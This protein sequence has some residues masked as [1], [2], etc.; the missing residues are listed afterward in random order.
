[1]KE[2]K[3]LDMYLSDALMERPYAFSAGAFRFYLY[4][5]TFGKMQ[6]LQR[7][8]ENLDIDMDQLQKDVSI[9][10]LRLAKEKRDECLTVITYHTCKTKDELFDITLVNERKSIFD[11]EMDEEDI[12]ALM[13]TVLTSDK[14]SLFIKHLGIDREQERTRV[15]SEI[16]ARSDR[17]SITIGG[18]SLYGSFIAPL[19]EMGLSWDEIMWGRSYTNLRLLLADK[20]NTMYLSDD[21]MKS[22]PAWAKGDGKVIKADDPRNKDIIK[23]M[24]WK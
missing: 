18:K 15:V 12:A 23:Q 16:K 8:M 3:E 9:E 20:I 17:N 11:K 13:I 19:M 21:E 10:A 14:T 7:Q 24:N 22:V 2:N 4:P 5:V 1:M 6:L